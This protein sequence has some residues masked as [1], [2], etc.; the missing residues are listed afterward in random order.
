MIKPY[1]PTK[2]SLTEAFVVLGDSIFLSA[3]P[4]PHGTPKRISNKCSS[5]KKCGEAN[6]ALPAEP[7]LDFLPALFFCHFHPG[8]DWAPQRDDCFN[9]D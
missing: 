7:I 3:T 9:C 4:K 2:A 8:T 1:K 5:L 6:S